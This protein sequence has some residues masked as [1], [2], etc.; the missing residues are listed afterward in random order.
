VR[1]VSNN[2]FLPFLHKISN[3]KHPQRHVSKGRRAE[4]LLKSTMTSWKNDCKFPADTHFHFR[5]LTFAAGSN[6]ELV[7][8]AQLEGEW[9]N[10]RFPPG[11][12][13][14]TTMLMGSIKAW[15]CTLRTH[16]EMDL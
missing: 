13:N 14:S 10:F 4:I 7:L 8:Q 9:D 1:S 12:K 6:G 11:L 3:D 5:T 16:V 2:L 15:G